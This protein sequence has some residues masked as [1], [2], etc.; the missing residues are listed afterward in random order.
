LP[1]DYERT[2][3]KGRHTNALNVRLPDETPRHAPE[4]DSVNPDTATKPRMPGVVDFAR[5]NI[6][7]VGLRGCIM[8]PGRT[9]R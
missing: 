3:G 6:M 1:V 8:N 5:F 4:A 7:G 9:S 2:A